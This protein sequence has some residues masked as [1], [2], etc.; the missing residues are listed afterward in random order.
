MSILGRSALLIALAGA[1][2]VVVMALLSRRPH[3]RAF[4]RSAERGVYGVA[5]FTTV[6]VLTMWSA[7]L[8][9]SFELRDVAGYSSTTLG[10]GSALAAS[11]TR[12]RIRPVPV[13][14]IVVCDHG[15]ALHTSSRTAVQTPLRQA[16]SII[17]RLLSKSAF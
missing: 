2:Y 13:A 5:A 8:S 10:T 15:V 16:R 17:G 14:G 6:A 9:D 1:L 12:P 4:E 3:R 11:T 7:L